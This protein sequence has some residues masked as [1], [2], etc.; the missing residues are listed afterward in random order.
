MVRFRNLFLK[1]LLY[2]KIIVI[3]F[4]IASTIIRNAL[5][6]ESLYKFSDADRHVYDEYLKQISRF[7]SVSNHY[8]LAK[9]YTLTGNLLWKNKLHEDAMQFFEKALEENK[10]LEN[11]NAIKVLNNN[12]GIICTELGKDE[13][14]LNYFNESLKINRELNKKTEIAYD[15]INIGMCLQNLGRYAESNQKLQEALELTKEENDLKTMKTCYGMMA[16]NYEKLGNS[17]KSMEYYNQFNSIQKFLSSKK[18]IGLQKLKIRR[19][20]AD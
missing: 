10:I 14:A 9:Y 7:E 13:T 16:E 5:A 4:F 1:D 17:A 6:Q 8:E 12:I 3:L 20:H 11:R 15:L 2:L 19:K 18:L